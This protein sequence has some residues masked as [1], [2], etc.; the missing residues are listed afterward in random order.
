MFPI[1]ILLVFLAIGGSWATY[2][3]PWP[4][5]TGRWSSNN[6]QRS[7]EELYPGTYLGEGTAHWMRGYA[8]LSC[9][10]NSFEGHVVSNVVWSKMRGDF[11]EPFWPCPQCYPQDSRIRAYDHY[12]KSILLMK[13]PGPQD[14][15]VYR[16]T[17]TGQYY[18]GRVVTIYQIVHV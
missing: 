15:G 8:E 13:D 12:G 4:S 1:H 10:L 17:A 11:E 9:T 7:G 14:R 6:N 3:Y 18:D 2:Y 5:N 16:C